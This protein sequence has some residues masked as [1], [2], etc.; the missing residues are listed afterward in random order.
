MRDDLDLYR[1]GEVMAVFD[2]VARA[3]DRYYAEPGRSALLKAVRQDSNV[4]VGAGALVQHFEIQDELRPLFGKGPAVAPSIGNHPDF[5][6]L[7]RTRSIE[8][9]A[10]T[11]LFLDMEGSTRLGLVYGPEQVFWIKNAVIQSTIDIIKSF[12]G[13]V[14]RIMGDA[15]MAF[16]GSKSLPVEQGAIDA[17]NCA[18]TLRAMIGTLVD[19][20][21]QEMGD[22]QI[23]IRI[24]IDYGARDHVLWGCYGYPGME[25]VSATSFYVDVASKLQ[26][27][28]GRNEIM[29]GQSLRDLIDIPEVLLQTKTFI[30]NGEEQNEL[31]VTPNYRAGDG[32]PVNYRQYLLNW[33]DYLA[34]TELGPAAKKIDAVRVAVGVADERSDTSIAGSYLP[35]GSMLEKRKQLR[36]SVELPF[37]PRLPFALDFRVEN[38][39][40]EAGNAPER[41]NHSTREEKTKN[42][43][44]ACHHW[45]STLYR[46]LHYLDV[47]VST[48]GKQIVKR[49]LGVWVQ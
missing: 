14:H 6:H 36:F 37:Q 32:K 30:K 1:L 33:E 10:V 44:L 27:A 15:V 38:H 2:A 43:D 12:D 35:C 3:Y 23:G 11:T 28:A 26:H 7:K 18:V 40:A 20:R 49:R 8:F 17:L 5:E 19:G 21:L 48:Q 31:Y 4:G 13:H 45:E 29:V 25:E 41:G 16:F 24:G 22:E 34:C 9:A 39:G 47:L 46:G 42:G